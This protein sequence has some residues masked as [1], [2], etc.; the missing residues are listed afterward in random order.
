MP[1]TF[2]HCEPLSCHH[3]I[4]CKTIA[5]STLSLWQHL[6]FF[7]CKR[8]DHML[9]PKSKKDKAKTFIFQFSTRLFNEHC[10]SP[11]GCLLSR[12]SLLKLQQSTL[13]GFDDAFAGSQISMSE[14]HSQTTLLIPTPPS[15]SRSSVSDSIISLVAQAKTLGTVFIPCFVSHP[16]SKP[17]TNSL[18]STFKS[19][20]FALLPLRTKHHHISPGLLKQQLPVFFQLLPLALHSLYSPRGQDELF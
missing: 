3:I 17:R 1:H 2:L 6:H 14:S 4:M 18:C 19:D 15:Q 10:E 20:R 7:R 16:P 11:T 9:F 12:Q 5:S 13:P 8:G